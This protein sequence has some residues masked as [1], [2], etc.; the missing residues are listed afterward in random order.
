MNP[1]P[2]VILSDFLAVTTFKPNLHDEI[3][4]LN[5]MQFVKVALLLTAGN[6]VKRYQKDGKIIRITI[7]I[8]SKCK[9]FKLKKTYTNCI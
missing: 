9:P 2:S 4:Q 5:K 8:W 1:F 7:S 3:G 6:K